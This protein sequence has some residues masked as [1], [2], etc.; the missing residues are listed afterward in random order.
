METEIGKATEGCNILTLYHICMKTALALKKSAVC[1]QI[2]F[3]G[4]YLIIRIYN[5]YSSKHLY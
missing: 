5:D 2:A 3:M 1:R 4:F